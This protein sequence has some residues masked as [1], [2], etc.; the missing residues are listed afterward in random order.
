MR[1][2][3]LVVLGDFG[4]EQVFQFS[5]GSRIG[6]LSAARGVITHGVRGVVRVGDRWYAGV[7]QNHG[8]FLVYELTASAATLLAELPIHGPR[9][10]VRAQLV[11]SVPDEDLGILVQALGVRSVNSRWAIYPLD[12]DERSV[13]EPIALD[14]QMLGRQPKVCEG[15]AH[16]WLL[17]T[18]PPLLPRVE[19]GEGR[20]W[21][22]DVFLRGIFDGETLC[23]DALGAWGRVR[24]PSGHAR[25]PKRRGATLPL[26]VADRLRETRATLRCSP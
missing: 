14:Q 26:V 15:D 20:V 13:G 10:R 9:G 4:N 1:H 7:Q 16:G 6:E 12:R 18:K 2:T 3:G 25:A 5:Q 17:A 22:N 19:V 21:L 23:V 24:R 8:V 11:R